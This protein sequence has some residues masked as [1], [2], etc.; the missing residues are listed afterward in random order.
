MPGANHLVASYDAGVHGLLASGC[1]IQKRTALPGFHIERMH[2]SSQDA[3]W[4]S[5][6]PRNVEKMTSSGCSPTPPTTPQRWIRVETG[7]DAHPPLDMAWM[8]R[9]LP[10]R[11]DV[12]PGERELLKPQ[13]WEKVAESQRLFGLVPLTSFCLGVTLLAMGTPHRLAHEKNPSQQGAQHHECAR[14][15]RR[16]NRTKAKKR[17]TP[18][19]KEYLA[20]RAQNSS[21]DNLRRGVG[22]GHCPILERLLVIRNLFVLANAFSASNPV[23]PI[24]EE[25]EMSSTR[26][27]RLGHAKLCDSR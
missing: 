3:K 21:L 15:G 1:S 2:K 24:F 22:F 11:V 5:P 9:V 19:V 10:R 7:L 6:S 26:C 14:G 25:H 8:P 23:S 12:N 20:R 27:G 4:D 18:R 13:P 16:Q 17:A